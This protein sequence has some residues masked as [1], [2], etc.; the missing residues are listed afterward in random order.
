MKCLTATTVLIED[1]VLSMHE[2]KMQY[3]T[4]RSHEGLWSCHVYIISIHSIITM[5]TGIGPR[6]NINL[7]YIRYEETPFGL[8]NPSSAVRLNC[9]AEVGQIISL[10]K[11]TLQFS[12]G[13]LQV[14]QEGRGPLIHQ[15]LYK[16]FSSKANPFANLS[17]RPE[18]SPG[19]S[20]LLCERKC[21]CCW[22]LAAFTP[23]ML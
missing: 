23:D 6:L 3:I 19:S 15:T 8:Y 11:C 18:L 21:L 1:W 13:L 20:W 2:D 22:H 10:Q 12:S 5:R 14:D 9:T 4:T 17:Q 16:E 7:G